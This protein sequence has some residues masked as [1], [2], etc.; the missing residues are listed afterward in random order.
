VTCAGERDILGLW[1]GDGGEGAKFWLPK[2]LGPLFMRRVVA[3]HPGSGNELKMWPLAHYA[4]LIDLCLIAAY[5]SQIVGGPKE[6]A[7]CSAFVERVQD[8][9]RVYNLPGQLPLSELPGL[10]TRCALFIGNDGGPKQIA[11]GLGVPTNW[12]SLAS[13][14]SVRVF[15]KRGKCTVHHEKHLVLA[16]LPG[17]LRGASPPNGLLARSI[18]ECRLQFELQAAGD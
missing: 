11:A 6:Q 2:K 13:S 8:P 5:T 14:G 4:D 17:S 12:D 3:T 15:V 7:L 18:R 9:K 10:L 16:V 1:A